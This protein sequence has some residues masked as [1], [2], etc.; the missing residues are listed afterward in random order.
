M[1]EL[2]QTGLLCVHCEDL[3]WEPSTFAA[4]LFVKNVAV[5][6]GFEMQILRFEPGAQ[7][8]LHQHECLS[9]SISWKANSSWQ[10]NV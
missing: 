8:P 4:G 1:N 9:S 7:L 5:T 6:G 2:D 10:A 3:A